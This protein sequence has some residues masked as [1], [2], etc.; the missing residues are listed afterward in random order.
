MR[1]DKALERMELTLEEKC[2]IA[3]Y[4]SLTWPK[5]AVVRLALF[6]PKLAPFACWLARRMS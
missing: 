5:R 3:A 1:N 6:H 2:V 4:R